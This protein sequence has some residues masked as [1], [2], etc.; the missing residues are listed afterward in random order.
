MPER[1]PS[2]REWLDRLEEAPTNRVLAAIGYVPFLC[3]IPI[4][5]R[6]DDRFARFHGKQS[7]VLLGLLVGGWVLIWIL[8]LVA[9]R[10]LGSIFLVGAVFRLIAWIVH[11][12][13]GGTLSVGYFV[14][15]TACAIQSLAGKTWRIPVVGA[16]AEQ[17][18]I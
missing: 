16:I 10:I 11:Y 17:L 8:D 4:L 7:M 2:L 3:I 6:R 5:A 12:L 14:A 13:F 1:E 18:D 9:G 15:I